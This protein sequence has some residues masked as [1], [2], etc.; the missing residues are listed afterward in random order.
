MY[1][2][3]LEPGYPLS[4]TY[5]QNWENLST[6]I[7]IVT[8]LRRVCVLIGKQ[9]AFIESYDFCS[10]SYE[11][12]SELYKVCSPQLYAYSN[13]ILN[14]SSVV[15]QL[16]ITL[17]RFLIVNFRVSLN[18]LFSRGLPDAIIPGCNCLFI[19]QFN[20]NGSSLFSFKLALLRIFEF[21]RCKL[22]VFPV[23]QV[24]LST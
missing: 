3:G 5:V 15:F 23:V 9:Q 22:F 14:N 16:H 6:V 12:L 7:G 8:Q 1:Q 21:G 20:L 19:L 10:T 2:F 4:G 11:S 13:H 18:K 17:I 24:N